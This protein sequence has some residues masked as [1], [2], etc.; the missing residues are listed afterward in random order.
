[1]ENKSDKNVQVQPIKVVSNFLNSPVI[2]NKFHELLGKKSQGFIASVLAACSSNTDL[3]KAIPETIY[4][5]ALM[6]AVLDLPINPNLGFAFLVPYKKNVGKPNETVECQFQIAAKGFKQ[7]A[8]RSGRFLLITDAIVYEGQLVEENPLIG[9]KFDWKAKKSDLIIGYV[10]YFKLINGFEST[11]YMSKDKV[12]SHAKKYS[13]TYKSSNKWVKDSSKWTT[14][15]DA[16]A[17]KTVTKLN[18][19]K[20]APLSIEM[21]Q[22]ILSD[23]AVLNENGENKYLDNP[24]PP[25]Q[26]HEDIN[27]DPELENAEKIFSACKTIESLDAEFLK[28]ESPDLKE[29]IKDAYAFRKGAILK[30]N[31]V[32]MP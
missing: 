7:L 27:S 10:S 1:M 9:F 17:L 8:Q 13:Q 2:K 28:M 23:Q 3:S 18:L 30:F 25:V 5:A 31:D 15:F 4:S 21:Q 6:A 12:E 24:E 29:S 22:A 14:D 20:N 26:E 16:M 32:K 11:Y 19:S